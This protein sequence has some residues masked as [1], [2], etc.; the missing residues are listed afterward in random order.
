MTFNKK[1]KHN[2]IFDIVIVLPAAAVPVRAPPS[3]ERVYGFA[4]ELPPTMQ[5]AMAA[6]AEEERARRAKI[7]AADGEFQASERLAEAAAV[8]SKEPISLQLRYLQ[9]LGEI[10]NDNSNTIVFPI[11]MD[12]LNQFINRDSSTDS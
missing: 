9:T 11:P 8:M 6:Q 10:S 3:S 4:L 5:R 2:T 12:I 1:K 7:I